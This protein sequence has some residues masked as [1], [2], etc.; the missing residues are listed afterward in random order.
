MTTYSSAD[1]HVLLGIRKTIIIAIAS[2]D[3][4][5]ER[6]VLKGGNALD[7]I[8]QLSDRSS[9][10]LDFSMANDVGSAE[11]LEDFCVREE[12]ASH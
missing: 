8:Y 12:L 9:L 5:M 3:V 6:L 1:E 4:L 7:I 2:D 10:D 11:E